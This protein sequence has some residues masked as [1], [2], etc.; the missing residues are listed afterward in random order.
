MIKRSTYHKSVLLLVGLLNLATAL[1]AQESWGKIDGKLFVRKKSGLDTSAH[2]ATLFA[3]CAIS[4]EYSHFGYFV[5]HYHIHKR[6]QIFDK[7]G[8]ERASVKIHYYSRGETETITELRAHTLNTDGRGGVTVSKVNEAGIFDEQLSYS[9][10]AKKIAF[11]DIKE[12]SVIEYE[13]TLE[14]T[15][16][17]FLNDWTF[18][19]DIPTEYSRVKIRIPEFLHYG[20]NVQSSIPVTEEKKEAYMDYFPGALINN[21]A[22][23]V[24]INGTE[25][26]YIMKDVPALK[27]EGYMTAIEDFTSKISFA[28]ISVNVPNRPVR[29]FTE[30]WDDVI[31]ELLKSE[32]FGL[33]LNGIGEHLK[34]AKL[35]TEGIST[36][37][38]KIELLYK[39]VSTHVKWNERY[40]HI[41][42]DKLRRIYAEG[43]GNSADINMLLVDMLNAAGVQA[44]PV[45]IST[46][47]NG[48]VRISF[49]DLTQF[50]HVLALA[51]TDS[52][53]ILL[54][55]VNPSRPY[56]M[57]GFS[58][59]NAI[60]L[61]VSTKPEWIKISPN[62]NVAETL[63]ST[64][65][66]DSL[67]FLK[68]KS[69]LYANGYYALNFMD[70]LKTKSISDGLKHQYNFPEGFSISGVST[71]SSF[72]RSKKLK[73]N[74]ETTSE[75]PVAANKII[76]LNPIPAKFR[77]DNPF[78]LNQRTYPV[79][80]GHPFEEN[81]RLSFMVPPGYKVSEL[82]KPANIKLDDGS[83]SLSFL[84]AQNGNM[85]QINSSLKVNQV[86]YQPEAYQALKDFFGKVIDT[87]NF[88][89]VLEKE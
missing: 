22:D 72:D 6:I 60:G 50:N 59:L 49:P 63:I 3:V 38:E 2:A 80:F 36:P 46:R 88:T 21:A 48:R 11:P 9:I 78:K 10:A 12:G 77:I 16:W 76:Y 47:K 19:S 85:V 75:Q 20:A 51:V 71:D 67:G 35:L 5:T 14:S 64:V 57:L 55:A 65:E 74:F 68:S 87:Y 29:T 44:Y 15:R 86:E 84:V 8:F 27:E 41:P 62:K 56:Y 34:T 52:G 31:N 30:S 70:E 66:I 79:N 89:M 25:C 54:D 83:S 32:Y 82:P 7:E 1:T 40:S 17:R 4:F 37:T 39:H 61:K 58:D 45:L 13:Y 24:D 81:I 18:Q 28:L 43:K 69:S 23:R 42:S 73:I 33:L 26:T 53:N